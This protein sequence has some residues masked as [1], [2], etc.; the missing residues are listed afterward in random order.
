[1]AEKSKDAQTNKVQTQQP[2]SVEK[3]QT[4]SKLT[5]WLAEKKNI[6][7]K[8]IADNLDKLRS[9]YF[10]HGMTALVSGLASGAFAL[11]TAGSL[12]AGSL[13]IPDAAGV[14]VLGGIFIYSTARAL[15]LNNQIKKAEA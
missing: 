8:A 10:T 7:T 11:G 3:T 12:T 15:M 4:R 6:Q 9:S 14:V 2:V 5:T 13:S 1:M